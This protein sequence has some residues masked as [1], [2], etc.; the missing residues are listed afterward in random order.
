MKAFYRTIITRIRFFLHDKG[1]I[2]MSFIDRH[3]YVFHNYPDLTWSA[4][5]DQCDED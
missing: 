1:F 2:Q 4:Y 5:V 3:G